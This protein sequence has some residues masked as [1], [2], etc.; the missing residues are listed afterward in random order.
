MA[1]DSRQCPSSVQ[2]LKMTDVMIRRATP[3]DADGIA[4]VINALFAAGLRQQGADADWVRDRYLT[5]PDSL[6]AQV[7]V[8]E[9]GTILGLQSLKLATAG[10]PY[11]TPIGWGIIGTHISPDAHRLGLGRRFFEGSLLVA[12]AQRLQAIEAGVG[13]DVPHAQGYYHAMGFKSY[14]REGD[15]DYKAYRLS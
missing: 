10:N 8:A 7:A 6:L 13:V 5:D 3:E 2:V 15:V 4:A 11:N 14:R 12:K 1:A 9:D